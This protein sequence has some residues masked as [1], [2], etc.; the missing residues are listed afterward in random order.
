MSRAFN[1]IVDVFL[2]SDDRKAKVTQHPV[3]IASGSH[4]AIGG[5]EFSGML[6]AGGMTMEDKANE[7]RTD[8]R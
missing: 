1:T 7:Q 5:L 6:T 8:H 4:D 2:L 3:K